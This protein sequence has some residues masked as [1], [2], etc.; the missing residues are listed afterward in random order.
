MILCPQCNFKFK[1]SS[2]DPEIET[3][4][5]M[6]TAIAPVTKDIKR[7]ITEILPDQSFPP[8]CN[9][10]IPDDSI[11][12][13]VHRHSINQKGPARKSTSSKRAKSV[14]NV[15]RPSV[16]MAPP[17][18]FRSQTPAR[19][20]GASKPRGPGSFLYFISINKAAISSRAKMGS[21]HF[22]KAAS[23]LYKSF[24]ATSYATG[25]AT[26]GTAMGQ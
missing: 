12:P 20:L 4:A 17:R 19:M 3:S 22:M 6:P 1:L 21:I 2:K 11:P 5:S 14:T 9:Q 13:I 15:R 24:K 25:H 7:S 16:D 26:F 18:R 10:T 23:V 8:R